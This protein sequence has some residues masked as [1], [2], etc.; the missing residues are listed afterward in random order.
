MS[1]WFRCY[2]DLVD[3][4]KVQQLPAEQFKGLINLWCLA[5]KNDGVLPPIADIA[6]K[7]RI[8]ADKVAKLFGALRLAGLLEDDG[9]VTRPHNWN[10]R[11]FKSDTVDVTA[12]ERMR[13]YRE[14]RR[15][16]RN[17]DASVTVPRDRTEQITEKKDA[18]EAARP[19]F[20]V[21]PDPP[22]MT[23]AELER[24]YFDRGKQVL[25]R[26]AGGLLTKLMTAQGSVEMARAAIEIASD[27]QNPR[28]YIGAVL[29]KAEPSS[30]VDPRL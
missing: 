25:G 7:L 14:L 27:K 15:N 18:A 29:R 28:E 6:F 9:G 8:K 22:L 16:K 20:S 5:S 19:K 4:P 12:A 21:V 2:D 23:R 17:G 3:D 11:Q 1:R 30:Y 26:N 13:R 10:G 24:S